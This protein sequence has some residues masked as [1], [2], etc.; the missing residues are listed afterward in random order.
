MLF[1]GI[2]LLGWNHATA[3]SGIWS[4]DLPSLLETPV[5]KGQQSLIF[6]LLFAGLAVRLALFPLHS[7]LPIVAKHG[8]VA[9]GVVFLVGVTVGIYALLRF[10]LPLLPAA[11]QQWGGAVMALGLAGMLYGLSLIHI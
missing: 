3:T 6:I 11:A 1:A 10:V 7:W 2:V 8:T 9:L 5:P 4:F